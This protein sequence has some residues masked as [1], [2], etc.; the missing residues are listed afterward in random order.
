MLQRICFR[1]VRDFSMF[2]QIFLSPLVKRW[3]I[4]NYKHG[5]HEFPH[6]L[7]S[8]FGL[9]ILENSKTSVKYLNFMK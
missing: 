5:I 9:K 8:D 2:C 1:T 4:M 7:P 3:P 6:E